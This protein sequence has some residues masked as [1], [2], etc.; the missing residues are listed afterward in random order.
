M[1]TRRRT[2]L[3]LLLLLIVVMVLMMVLMVAVVVLSWGRTWRSVPAA[4]SV[5]LAVVHWRLLLIRVRR[6]LL[7]RIWR[8]IGRGIVA[9]A[10][11]WRV[12]RVYIGR[13]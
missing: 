11:W 9:L 6:D 1:L 3:L 13:S 10:L 2:P 8:L 5:L 4:L 12:R 7:T